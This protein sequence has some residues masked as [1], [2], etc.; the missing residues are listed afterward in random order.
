MG[1]TADSAE[2]S[3]NE[4]HHQPIQKLQIRAFH[5]ALGS[6]CALLGGPW[7]LLGD[8]GALLAPLSPVGTFCGV[9]TGGNCVLALNDG[10]NSQML[11]R[12]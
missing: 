7:P 4:S 1:L 12:C 10:E 9:C 2:L 11:L 3:F 5:A 6:S 8:L